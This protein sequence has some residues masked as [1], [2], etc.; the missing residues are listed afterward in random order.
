[1]VQV[2]WK[3]EFAFGHL[4]CNAVA[5]HTH[6][7]DFIELAQELKPLLSPLLPFRGSAVS[8]KDLGLGS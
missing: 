6:Y 1:M 3:F 7:L 8:G 2:K 5:V 4:L